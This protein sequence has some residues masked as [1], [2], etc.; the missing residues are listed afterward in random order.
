MNSRREAHEKYTLQANSYHGHKLIAY[1][2]DFIPAKHT[3]GSTPSPVFLFFSPHAA[4]EDTTWVL[5][6]SAR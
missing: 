1:G 6:K 3:P 4:S 5:G 2:L